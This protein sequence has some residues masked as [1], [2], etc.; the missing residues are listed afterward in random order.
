MDQGLLT[1]SFSE[2]AKGVSLSVTQLT[3]VSSKASPGLET[4]TL[5]SSTTVQES[6]N[7]RVFVLVLSEND[8]NAV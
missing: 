3:L 6:K 4:F 7:S 1:L 2:V 5:S 8:L